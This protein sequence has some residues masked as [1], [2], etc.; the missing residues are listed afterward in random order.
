MAAVFLMNILIWGGGLG[1]Q[2]KFNRADKN[3]LGADIPWDWT[4]SAAVGPII[5]LMAC[6]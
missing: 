4:T 6:E 1:F 3:V 5:L 2:V